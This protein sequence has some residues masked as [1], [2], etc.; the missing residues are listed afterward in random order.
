MHNSTTG[1]PERSTDRGVVQRPSVEAHDIELFRFSR[2][3]PQL[4]L[5][6]SNFSFLRFL[7]CRMM[8]FSSVT[9]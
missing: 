1:S 5:F 7:S 2:F 6:F 3:D 9:Q 4:D 8:A